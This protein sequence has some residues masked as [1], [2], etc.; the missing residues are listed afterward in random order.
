MIRTGESDPAIAEGD[1]YDP[2]GEQHAV[3]CFLGEDAESERDNS[4][5]SE[6]VD[7]WIVPNER[8]ERAA[9]FARHGTGRSVHLESLRIV[10]RAL[11]VVHD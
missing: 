7:A 8:R 1:V 11:G 2:L 9:V 3:A 5:A 4:A 10:G 6:E